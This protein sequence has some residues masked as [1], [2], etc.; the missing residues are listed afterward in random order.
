[1]HCYVPS[2]PRLSL[3]AMILVVCLFQRVPADAKRGDFVTARKL[4]QS[5]RA[6]CMTL[7]PLV[8]LVAFPQ[9][10]SGKTVAVRGYAHFEFEDNRLY[11]CKE[12]ADHLLKENALD[13]SFAPSNLLLESRGKFSADKGTPAL[14]ANREQAIKYFHG[15]YV[16]AVGDF[17]DG[18][19]SNI[20]RLAELPTAN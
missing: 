18:Q 10:Y 8:S 12:H 19:L 11:L 1:M 9:R 17:K 13:L 16:L 6:A 7:T 15:K 4:T 14:P 5:E 3:I 20:S 2:M